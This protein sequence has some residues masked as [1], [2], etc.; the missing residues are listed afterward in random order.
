[1]GRRATSETRGRAAAPGMDRLP[2]C[3]ER[4]VRNADGKRFEVAHVT[5]IEGGELHFALR[6]ADGERVSLCT[7]GF[8]PANGAPPFRFDA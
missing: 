8:F 5:T 3:E 2:R 4:L 6:A 7:E 1:M